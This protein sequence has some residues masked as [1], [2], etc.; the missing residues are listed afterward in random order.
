[1][2]GRYQC[3]ETHN[4]ARG[5]GSSLPRRAQLRVQAFAWIAFIGLP[6]PKKTAGILREAVLVSPGIPNDVRSAAG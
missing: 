4:T 5:R 3:A 2:A 1:V 6:C